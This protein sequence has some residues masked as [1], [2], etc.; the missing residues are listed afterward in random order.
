MSSTPSGSSTGAAHRWIDDA[1]ELDAVVEALVDAPRYALDTEFHRERT[2]YP[3]LALVQLAYDDEIVLIDPLAVDVAPLRQVLEGPGVAIVHAGQQDLEILDRACGAVPEVLFDTQIA[4][5]FVGYATPSLS[6]LA[7][8]ELGFRLPKGDR[9]ADWLAR[10]LRDGQRDYAAADVAHLCELHARLVDQ[11]T[12]RGRLGWALD[13]C[14]ILLE[15][16]RAPQDP[17]TAWKRIKEARHLRGSA[18]A[19]VRELAAWREENAAATDQPVRFVLSDLAAVGI[20][21]RAPTDQRSLRAI[22]GVDGRHLRDGA[23]DDIL[24]AVRRGRQI[25]PADLDEPRQGRVGLDGALRPAVTLVTAWV[26]QVARDERF[27]PALLATRGDIEGFLRDDPSSRLD[28]G[29]R[30][31]LLGGPIEDL[32]AGR[33]ALAFDRRR[34]LAL[35]PRATPGAAGG[36]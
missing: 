16:S 4:A 33:A 7:E 10:P 18:Q 22:R 24:E 1:D 36:V 23:A 17:A 15:R 31:D 20:A 2:Y 8:G 28:A 25:D 21:Q 27:D 35:E 30:R 3:Q 19:I 5:G 6:A 12:S 13:E 29:W 32:V 14:K 11:L 26:A 34:G 9:L